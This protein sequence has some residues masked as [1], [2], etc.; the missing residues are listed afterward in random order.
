MAVAARLRN[1]DGGQQA[2]NKQSCLHGGQAS[3]TGC[4]VWMLWVASDLS[5]YGMNVKQNTTVFVK[6]K[7]E[8]MP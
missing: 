6:S 7:D 2:G 8:S 1:G 3:K 4:A 5:W